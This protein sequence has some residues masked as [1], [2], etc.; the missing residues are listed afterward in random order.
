M[1]ILEELMDL[2]TGDPF[3]VKL[4]GPVLWLVTHFLQP[5]IN[6]LHFGILWHKRP[7]GDFVIIESI[8]RGLSIGL[9]S[10]YKDY[11]KT[12]YRVN[13]PAELRHKAPDALVEW[14][15]ARYDH[16]LVLKL[17]LGAVVAFFKILVKERKVRKLRAE[18]FPYAKNS[19]LICTEVP[20]V[21]YDAVGVNI[22][23]IGVVPLPN[24]FRQAAIEGRLVEITE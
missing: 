9:L 13:C 12:F 20:D 19:S 11:E 15:R 23:P 14:G 1:R 21:A 8:P 22:I 10:W 17:A 7:D 18:D 3:A 6:R 2:Q 24:A 4:H 16:L 5:Y